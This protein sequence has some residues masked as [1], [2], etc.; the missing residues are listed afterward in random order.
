M[1]RSVGQL[2]VYYN[3]KNPKGHDYVE[4]SEAPLYPFGF[5]LSYTSFEY[6]NLNI[7]KVNN[8]SYVAEFTVTNAGNFDGDEVAQLYLRDEVASTVRPVKQLKHFSRL[9][10]KK[11]ESKKVSFELSENDF[12]IIDQQMN[13]IV[14]P[15]KFTIMIGS[16]SEDIKLKDI[17]NIENI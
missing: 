9:N 10:L 6:S 17:I 7:R 11:G 8:T 3:K 2:P 1:P 5:G 13:R 4:M 15:G 12:T 16:S 14:E